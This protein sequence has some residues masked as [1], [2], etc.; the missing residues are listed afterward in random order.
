MK[1]SKDSSLDFSA[2]H[3]PCAPIKLNTVLDVNFF[4]I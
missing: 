3:T 2:K 4:M 1:K